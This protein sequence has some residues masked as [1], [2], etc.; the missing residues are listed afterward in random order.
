MRVLVIEDDAALNG[1]LAKRL[2]EEGHSVDCCFDGRDG[3]DYAEAEDY[4]CIVLDWMLPK[5]DGLTLLRRLRG[6]GNHANVLLLTAKDSIEDRVAGL[7][8]GADDYLVKP[9]S[10]DELLARVRA[11]LRR[12]SEVRSPVLKLDDLVMDTA[13]KTVQRGGKKLLLTSKEYALLEYLLRHQGQTLT[14]SQIS[15][16]VW[17]FDFDYD[18]NIVDVY[19]RYLRNKV[20]KPFPNKL[21]HTVRGFGYVMRCGDA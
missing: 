9:F 3:L 15:D 14:R 8:A 20:D 19:I 2:A 6:G 10:F 18:S 12:Q 13:S 11:L 21:I 4:D 16:H 5:M 17:N 7:D 1:I